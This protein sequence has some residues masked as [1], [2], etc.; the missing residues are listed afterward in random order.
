MVQPTKVFHSKSAAV[1]KPK[2]PTELG[3][4]QL[5]VEGSQCCGIVDKRKINFTTHAIT[6]K[7][8]I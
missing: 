3:M 8:K 1:Q 2:I 6:R 5:C 7:H 4:H